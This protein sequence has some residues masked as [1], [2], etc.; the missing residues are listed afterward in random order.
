[1]INNVDDNLRRLDK[2][3]CS[4]FDKINDTSIDELASEI[5]CSDLR[6]L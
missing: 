1:M 2:I 3:F 6:N 5:V 4:I